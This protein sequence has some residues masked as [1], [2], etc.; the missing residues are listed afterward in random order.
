LENLFHG[1][2]ARIGKEAGKPAV[3]LLQT[4]LIRIRFIIES[5]DKLEEECDQ[6]SLG[7]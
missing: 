2:G 7:K 4:K 1:K 5:D 3:C 6:F